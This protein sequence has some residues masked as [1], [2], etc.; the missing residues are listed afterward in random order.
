M[1]TELRTRTRVL[2][3]IATIFIVSFLCWEVVLM[4]FYFQLGSWPEAIL[5]HYEGLGPSMDIQGQWMYGSLVLL[6]LGCTSWYLAVRSNRN[7]ASQK[8]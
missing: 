3:A 6:L 8:K 1:A 2:K 4:S 5:G 7:G